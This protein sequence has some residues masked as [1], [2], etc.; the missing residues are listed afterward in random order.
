MGGTDE[1]TAHQDAASSP[2]AQCLIDVYKRYFDL[3]PKMVPEERIDELAEKIIS[4]R[5]ICVWGINRTGLSAQQLSF[6]LLCL[7]IMNKVMTDQAAMIDDA[8]IVGAGD[9][10]IAFTVAGRGTDY[11]S[12][13]RDAHAGGAQ[14]ALIS[15]N[16]TL[17]CVRE[18]D[19]AIVLPWI[20]HENRANFFE[21][22]L[23]VY[24]FIEVLLLRLS[25]LGT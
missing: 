17:E 2:K 12:L 3:I 24:M 14:I 11:L 6:R 21:D 19:I 8:S 16:S 25:H 1:G 22:Q 18:A 9:L 10:C 20:S 15:M 4:A 5:R 7:G 23:V 13:V